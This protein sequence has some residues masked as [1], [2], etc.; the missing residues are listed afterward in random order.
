ML[1]Y[2]QFGCNFFNMYTFYTYMYVCREIVQ[3]RYGMYASVCDFLITERT[4]V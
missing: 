3:P 4:V 1:T 2:N